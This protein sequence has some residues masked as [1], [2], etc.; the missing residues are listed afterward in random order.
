MSLRC[1]AGRTGQRFAKDQ[2]RSIAR[3]SLV[4]VAASEL[5]DAF[6]SRSAMTGQ[7]VLVVQ[8]PERCRRLESVGVVTGRDPAGGE[9]ATVS[10]RQ[11]G[12]AGNQDAIL[13]PPKGK[14]ASR[15]TG[16]GDDPKAS[17]RVAVFEDPVGLQMLDS[18]RFAHDPKEQAQ[19]TAEGFARPFAG[20]RGCV[21]FSDRHGR[22]GRLLEGRCSP[23]VIHVSV[24][25][26]EVLHTFGRSLLEV[27]K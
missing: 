1:A 11:Q 10:I 21:S 4:P 17:Y 5:I 18:Y 16:D 2:S 23:D 7:E 20:Q 24:S 14:T 26:D 27:A 13:R 15:M 22:P 19:G 8:L 25:Q 6:N 3:E 9:F 12:I